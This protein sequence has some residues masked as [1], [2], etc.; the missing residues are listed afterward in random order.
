MRSIPLF[1]EWRVGRQ[2]RGSNGEWNQHCSITVLVYIRNRFISSEWYIRGRLNVCLVTFG[3]KNSAVSKTSWIEWSASAL[4][5]NAISPSQPFISTCEETPI[6]S[7]TL[8]T[9]HHVKMTVLLTPRYAEGDVQTHQGRNEPTSCS[10]E[11]VEATP[12]VSSLTCC[13]RPSV[14]MTVSADEITRRWLRV[15]RHDDVL[16]YTVFYTVLSKVRCFI[17]RDDFSPQLSDLSLMGITSP[18]VLGI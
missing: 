5:Y 10:L 1:G 6:Q 12:R 9:N 18:I 15:D 7:I 8:T 4:H 16:S 13:V 11:E 17:W 14:V 3:C 2:P